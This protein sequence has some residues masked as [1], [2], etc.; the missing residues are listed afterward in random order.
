MRSLSIILPAK[1][2]A[3][4][5]RRTLPAL[6]QSFADAEIIVVNDGSTDD[7]ATVADQAGVRVLT[8]PYSMG[9]GA[10]IKR[11]AR[12]ASGEV[13][14]FMDADGQHNAEHIAALLSK[15]EGIRTYNFPQGRMTDHRINL[16]LYALDRIMAGDLGEVVQALVAH[17]QAGKLAEMEQ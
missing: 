9:N 13:L 3:E 1:N 10:A 15:L 11:G 2:E 17:D 6:R 14:V 12:A 8:S 4:G 5:L 16:T 7:T